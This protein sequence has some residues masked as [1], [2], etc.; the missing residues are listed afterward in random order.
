MGGCAARRNAC[1]GSAEVS[2][3]VLLPLLAQMP[4]QLLGPAPQALAQILGATW[5]GWEVA[6]S[7]GCARDAAAQAFA[8][9]L[10]WAICS[11]PKVRGVWRTQR[12][13][14]WVRCAP[15]CHACGV[16]ESPVSKE[17]DG[18][19]RWAAGEMLSFPLR[20]PL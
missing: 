11:S 4:A 3:P 20:S 15:V 14:Q 12:A 10:A 8:E 6:G 9:C 17:F 19:A 16:T 1:Y 18:V 7:G 13:P 5:R 2:F